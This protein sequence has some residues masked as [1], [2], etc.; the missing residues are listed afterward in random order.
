MKTYALA[1]IAAL[2]LALPAQAGVLLTDGFEGETDGTPQPMLTNFTVTSPTIDIVTTPN[3]GITCAGGSGK[4]LDLDGTPGL[5]GILTKGSWA[6]QAGDVFTLSFFASGN[7]RSS[8]GFA[9]SFSAGFLLNGMT[10]INFDG[11]VLAVNDPFAQFTYS[12]TALGTG[13]LQAFIRARGPGSDNEGVVID[14]VQLSAVPEPAT[15]LMMIAG[16]GFIGAAMRRKR[17][18]PTFARA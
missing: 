4:C 6:F 17:S 16:F 10:E 12:Y 3:F 8:G 18:A 14:N 15:W 9:D 2:A 7:Q 5:G 1:A 11:P 13:T